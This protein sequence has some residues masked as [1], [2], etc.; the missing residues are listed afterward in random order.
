MGVM[1]TNRI[2][3]PAAWLGADIADD[4][5]WRAHLS[6]EEI[7]AIDAA[8]AGVKARGLAPPRFTAADFPLGPLSTR[9]AAIADELEEGKGFF[10]LRGLPVDRWS[11]EEID[12][13]YYG[14]GL[15]L[16][17]PVGQNPAGDLI[18]RVMAVGDPAKKETR[19][20]ET[21]LYL[22]YHTDPSDVVGL[23]CI[24]KARTGGLS[25]LV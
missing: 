25:S 5:S 20:F 4:E 1:L 22:P 23:L 11:E 2:D 17:Q 14:V 15:H 10:L 12:T 8:L 9:L 6:G 18:G 24:R 21:S 7:D 16:G 3:G 19:V 13:V